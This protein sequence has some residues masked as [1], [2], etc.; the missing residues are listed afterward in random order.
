MSP[1]SVDK[2]HEHPGHVDIQDDDPSTRSE[3]QASPVLRNSRGWDGKLR[4]P[5]SAFVT[6]PEALSD[7]EYSD[8]SNVLPGEELGPDEGTRAILADMAFHGF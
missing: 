2:E 6:N 1:S 4:V 7:P 8:D 3:T 5:R